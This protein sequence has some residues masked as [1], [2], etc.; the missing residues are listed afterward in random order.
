M[1]ATSRV[2]PVTAFIL[3]ALCFGA[4]PA[5]GQATAPANS[6]SDLRKLQR[7]A[8][9]EAVPFEFDVRIVFVAHDWNRFRLQNG[10][11]SFWAVADEQVRAKIGELSIGDLIRVQGHA[12]PRDM[13]SKVE[14]FDLIEPG[15]VTDLFAMPAFQSGRVNHFRF[16]EAKGV[17]REVFESSSSSRLVVDVDGHELGVELFAPLETDSLASVLGRDVRV[18][19]SLGY[20]DSPVGWQN[21]RLRLLA[22]DSSQVSFDDLDPAGSAV[23][24]RVGQGAVS[25]VAEDYLLVDGF[26]LNSSLAPLV[27]PGH[28]VHYLY[29][30]Q[31][32]ENNRVRPTSALRQLTRSSL[33]DPIVVSGSNLNDTSAL[34]RRCSVTGW[35]QNSSFSQQLLEVRIDSDGNPV[36]VSIQHS[37]SI[38]GAAA[39]PVGSLI[40]VTGTLDQVFDD[41]GNGQLVLRTLSSKD[42]AL[43]SYAVQFRASYL[44]WGLVGALGFLLLGAVWQFSLRRQVA[45]KT[46]ELVALNAQSVAVN[47][48][49]RD[50]IL[51]FDAHGCVAQCDERIEDLFGAKLSV[52]MTWQ[53]ALDEVARGGLDDRAA[54]QEFWQS[55]F[56][57]ERETRS[58]EF[59]FGSSGRWVA[60][61]TAD[62]VS[63]AGN[64][65]GRIWAFDEITERKHLEEKFSQS[66]RF[67]AIGRLAGGVA[68]DFNNLLQIVGANLDAVRVNSIHGSSSAQ[69]DSA[70]LAV[71]RAAEL[72]Q[73]LLT[74]SRRSQMSTNVVSIKFIVDEVTSL[75]RNSFG[76][77]IDFVTTISPDAWEIEADT[78]MIEQVLVNLCLNSKDA[79]QGNRGRIEISARNVTDETIGDC[80]SVTVQDDGA[81]IPSELLDHVFE[82]FYTTKGVGQGTGLGLATAHGIV[83]QHGGVIHCESVQGQGT[84]VEMLLPK[85]VSE[86]VAAPRSSPSHATRGIDV[87]RILLIDDEPLIRESVQRLLD[88]LGHSVVCAAGGQQGLDVLEMDRDFDL[89]ILDLTMPQM[90]GRE[91]LEKIRESYPGTR[92]VIC[93]GYSADAQEIS[94]S[95]IIR[96]DGY[97]SKP[98]RISD[99]N[100][101]LE[102]EDGRPSVAS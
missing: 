56:Q 29:A 30:P 44:I 53:D 71:D 82:P 22:M 67:N 62:V 97:L 34:Y 59:R 74:Y 4:V 7:G 38:D 100:R 95:D 10:N 21:R 54:L 5:S 57:N 58:A 36:N 25:F 35:V 16:V 83:E 69:I 64:S 17:V 49:V 92:V 8:P 12:G 99:F 73:Q 19:G 80:L 20:F 79:L 76:Q 42:V 90:S 23:D 13:N 52:G 37:G 6:L 40:Q 15:D 24:W 11:S 46:R 96:P 2:L 41:A 65:F 27:R 45:L 94:D 3:L 75:M 102:V 47:R 63:K 51:L 28:L 50:V 84:R 81:G 101:L 91:T 85:A 48:A 31:S 33:P 60:I 70:S 55:A 32:D 61:Y 66:Q 18:F 72:T 78:G 68:H 86:V 87:K 1:F 39:Y 43:Q 89:V 98:F 26:R 14:S 9:A 93:S 77:E 88:C